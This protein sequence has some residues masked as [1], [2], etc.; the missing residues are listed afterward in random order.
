MFSFN[1]ELVNHLIALQVN[2]IS[3]SWIPPGIL[4]IKVMLAALAIILISVD[5]KFI[6]TIMNFKWTL[7][8]SS[9]K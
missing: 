1:Y 7:Q 9:I 8:M 4:N 2:I 5:K 6:M 3:P